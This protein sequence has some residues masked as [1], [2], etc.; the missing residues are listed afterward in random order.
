MKILL[1]NNI[2]FKKG[3]AEIVY[4]NTSKLLEQ[5]GH[6]VAFFSINHPANDQYALSDYFASYHDNRMVSLVGKIKAMPS[7]IYNREAY[8]KLLNLID[9]F[10]P[11]V[12]HIHLIFGGLT[13]SILQALKKRKVP[14]VFSVHDYRLICP[15]YLFIDGNSR[16][17]ELC[18]D[19]FYIR[20]TLK[21]CSEKNLLQSVMLS[22]D[23]YFRKYFMKPLNYIDSFIFVSR[24][25]QD[26]HISFCYA[27]KNKAEILY[28][29]IPDL[30]IIEPNES[31][32]RY[33]LYY[34]RL[35]REKGLETLIEVAESMK[36]K[37]KIIGTGTLSI[38]YKNK[39]YS[40]I[41][42]LGYKSGDELWNFVR[43]AS[44]IIV[45]SE[46]YENN[47]LTI[48]EA[49][50]NG[51]PVIGAR[52]G[53]ITEIIEHGKTG[54]LFKP[55]DKKQLQE[56]LSVA[57]QLDKQ[58]YVQMSKNARS[59]ANENFNP[60]IHYNKLIEIYKKLSSK[61]DY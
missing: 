39:T 6:E 57:D 34:G 50:A 20:C 9:E 52:I 2:H 37:L 27:Y 4:F 10:K 8:G 47:P 17:C 23:A 58:K 13:S 16:I 28:N 45:P 26:K 38:N 1:I 29:F 54:F 30:T 49:Y 25:A 53:G 48:L 36:L 46:W 5:H 51:K 19:Q 15:S 21:R 3:G 42:F 22:L 31:K 41:D 43:N 44:F 56:V 55:G 24:F 18:C 40:D 14:I 59:F 35:S 11:D 33:F 32:G 61:Y 7:F 12:A 60:L